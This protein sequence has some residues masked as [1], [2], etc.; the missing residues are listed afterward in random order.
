M[1]YFASTSEFKLNELNYVAKN[2]TYNG[3][4]IQFQLL[5]GYEGKE[6]QSLDLDEI[7]TE[8]FNSINWRKSE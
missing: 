3:K 4:P 8:K 6:I 5:P 1:F 7:I 2:Y